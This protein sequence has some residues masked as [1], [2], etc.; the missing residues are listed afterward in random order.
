MANKTKDWKVEVV[1]ADIE[2]YFD[3]EPS[4]RTRFDELV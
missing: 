3:F 1:E 2:E 4:A